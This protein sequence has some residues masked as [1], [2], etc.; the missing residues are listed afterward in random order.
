VIKQAY[1]YVRKPNHTLPDDLRVQKDL[2]YC[3]FDSSRKFSDEESKNGAMALG[4]LEIEIN[5]AQA[6]S[7]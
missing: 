2:R 7:H 4:V 3:L 5:Q 1:A 6:A